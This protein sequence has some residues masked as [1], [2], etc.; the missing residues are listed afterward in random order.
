MYR[1]HSA[2][3]GLH[4]AKSQEICSKSLRTRFTCCLRRFCRIISLKLPFPHNHLGDET[5]RCQFS[6]SIS[7][8]VLYHKPSFTERNCPLS[9]RALSVRVLA[10][11]FPF[12]GVNSN[13][14]CL[15]WHTPCWLPQY[16]VKNWHMWFERWSFLSDCHLLLFVMPRAAERQER[17]T[18]MAHSSWRMSATGAPSNRIQSFCEGTATQF[19]CQNESWPTPKHDTSHTMQINL[20]SC[21]SAKVMS[22]RFVG[23][24]LTHLA[25]VSVDLSCCWQANL[26]HEFW[27]VTW[28]LFWSDLGL[29]AHS[30]SLLVSWSVYCFGMTSNDSSNSVATW[31]C[32]FLLDIAQL[33]CEMLQTAVSLR[34]YRSMVQD[35]RRPGCQGETNLRRFEEG[36]FWI[37]RGP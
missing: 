8:R 16:I 27:E 12:P 31:N 19:P 2:R 13:S 34:E 5:W 14:L 9:V 37:F 33:S 7:C 26:W 4:Y 21:M 3:T 36:I 17:T 6:E 18:T 22:N 35:T 25:I 11:R 15:W 24:S 30:Y 1:I 10:C 28:A 23:H 29:C 20:D 32:L